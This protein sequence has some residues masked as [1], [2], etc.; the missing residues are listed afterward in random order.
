[1]T[2]L[3]PE[4]IRAEVAA[5]ITPEGKLPLKGLTRKRLE[6]WGVPWPPP[7]G[8]LKK[9]KAD[10]GPQ[11]K[12]VSLE[13]AQDIAVEMPMSV[14]VTPPAF[15]PEFLASTTFSWAVCREGAFIWWKEIPA[16][17]KRRSPHSSF[18]K[19]SGKGNAASM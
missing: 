4:E 17:E 14:P 10:C 1:M 2:V 13:F 11:P 15:V 8:W 5:R 18:W 6:S 3:S 12:R 19:A 16:L 7:K 9:L